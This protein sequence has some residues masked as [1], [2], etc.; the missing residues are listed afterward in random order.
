MNTS[1]SPDTD[2]ATATDATT[3]NRGRGRPGSAPER[4]VVEA[5]LSGGVSIAG[6][7]AKLEVPPSTLRHWI[8]IMGISRDRFRK[9]EAVTDE[10]LVERASASASWA[11]WHEGFRARPEGAALPYG[12]LSEIAR[13]A[14]ITK[15]AVDNWKKE[16]ASTEK[17]DEI[18]R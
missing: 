3:T 5:A 9:R 4:G 12:F 2:T 15:Q 8:K 6:A 11:D 14:G 1:P 17:L 7:A 18:F 10:M 16:G 13:R